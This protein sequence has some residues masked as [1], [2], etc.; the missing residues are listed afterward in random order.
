MR[1]AGA[2]FENCRCPR[3]STA[4]RR[5]PGCEPARRPAPRPGGRALAAFR[6]GL[7]ARRSAGPRSLVPQV[8]R[9]VAAALEVPD[10][11][12]NGDVLEGRD[13][14]AAPA[15]DDVVARDAVLR[16]A[17][18]LVA[19]V[20][21]A[22][23]FAVLAADLRLV[24]EGVVVHLLQGVGEGAVVP[25]GAGVLEDRAPRAELD[26]GAAGRD[27]A[28]NG[29][30]AQVEGAAARP[31]EVV[32]VVAALD[33]KVALHRGGQ[34][35]DLGA[36]ALQV[37][38]TENRHFVRAFSHLTS[39]LTGLWDFPE[40]RRAGFRRTGGLYDEPTTLC[41]NV[42]SL[43]RARAE[44]S[45]LS[46]GAAELTSAAGAHLAWDRCRGETAM[47]HC[48]ETVTTAVHKQTRGAKCRLSCHCETDPPGGSELAPDWRAPKKLLT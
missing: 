40:G 20:G 47:R 3:R 22:A 46:V 25:A 12:D 38:F 36:E 13:R 4:P 39:T 45:R 24:H 32:R 7:A 31:V 28:Q 34:R 18:D 29:G 41:S 43:L 10:V 37:F 17:V 1:P 15:R 9:D 5:A 19:V 42:S 35:A 26:V 2:N 21:S 11:V 23:P 48:S 14:D 27:V 16:Q 8:A 33:S 6:R 30:V 44:A